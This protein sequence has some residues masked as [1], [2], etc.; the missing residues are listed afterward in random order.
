MKET[1][2]Y[3]VSAYLGLVNEGLNRFRATVAGEVSSIDI[4]GNYL[5]FKLKDK[6]DGSV[7]SCFMWK[8]SFDACA[9]EL[10]EGAEIAAE[11]VPEIYKPR[12]TFTFQAAR[13]AVVGEGA[14][15]KAYDAMKARLYPEPI[16]QFE[17]QREKSDGAPYPDAGPLFKLAETAGV[18]RGVAEY[19]PE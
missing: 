9:V 2:P 16:L 1:V 15:K 14:L 11:G 5:F 12:G 3:S 17:A 4:R 6:H 8:R 10:Q 18:L 7:L 19:A 13:I